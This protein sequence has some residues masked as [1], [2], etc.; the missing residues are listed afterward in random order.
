R[1]DII[2]RLTK[3][4]MIIGMDFAR[5]TRAPKQFT[6]TVGND[7][8]RIHIGRGARTRLKNIKYKVLIK[9]ATD[10]FLGGP[11]NRFGYLWIK[12]SQFFVALGC[13]LFDLAQST[14]K[15]A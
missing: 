15:L 5:A 7:F 6:G 9:L 10:D 8:V 13:R 1:D 4:H 3:V 14:N 2:G 12:Q 11:Y